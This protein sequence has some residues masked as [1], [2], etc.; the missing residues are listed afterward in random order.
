MA[1]PG[2]QT[3]Y[4]ENLSRY[5]T[6]KRNGLGVT[7]HSMTFD[8][9]ENL[10]DCLVS[11]AQER[12]K[13]DPALTDESIMQSR[14]KLTVAAYD[15]ALRESM[16]RK[17]E[18]PESTIRRTRDGLVQSIA[19]YDPAWAD[20]P[21]SVGYDRGE[22]GEDKKARCAI[23]YRTAPKTATLLRDAR[24]SDTFGSEVQGM[25]VISPGVIDL[26][27]LSGFEIG[28]GVGKIFRI[29][30]EGQM[31]IDV[32]RSLEVNGLAFA[33]NSALYH[34]ARDKLEDENNDPEKR[35]EWSRALGMLKRGERIGRIT[36]QER[37]TGDVL[38]HDVE[39][40]YDDPVE[41]VDH[42]LEDEAWDL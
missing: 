5:V 2:F 22:N 8:R 11:S 15:Y 42:I 4:Q 26:E 10:V 32:E 34:Q 37:L 25:S 9:F 23:P 18:V 24:M 39:R 17:I 3:A 38:S 35:L 41:T 20:V 12:A 19:T 16:T 13:E 1:I 6:Q 40:R 21:L 36:S 29:V 7:E 33:A 30:G 31:E 14:P 28:A 27:D